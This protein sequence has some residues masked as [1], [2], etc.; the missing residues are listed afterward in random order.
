MQADFRT[1]TEKKN[2]KLLRDCLRELPG[3]CAQYFRGIEPQTTALT[4]LNYAYDLRLFFRFLTER[5]PRYAER[6]ILELTIA[7]MEKVQA[8]DLEIFME[9]ITLYEHGERELENHAP[10]K[11]RKLS[12]V[13]TMFRYLFK[14]EMISSN[15]ASLVDLPKK[16]EKPIIRLEPDEVARLLDTVETGGGLSERQRKFQ[17]Y[18][19]K[20]DV[21]LLTLFLSTGIRLSE[22][23]GID[24]GDIDFTVNGFTVTRKGG[25]RVILYFPEETAKAL[26]VYMEERSAVLP[27]PGHENALFLSLQRKRI[28]VRSVEA[29]VKRYAEV[30]APL[31]SISPHKL[32]STFGTALYR[33]TGDI[34][35]VADVLGHADV[36]TTRKHYAAMSDEKR[37]MA[38]KSIKLRED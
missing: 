36:N 7:D 20:R 13:R 2:T 4:R 29:L 21:A 35:L 22:C 31:K 12:S 17:E 28:N 5:V 30:A 1:Q 32:R 34:Y 24:I 27:C 18:T 11:E 26:R 23:V 37:R 3:F 10:G 6:N 19:K 38:A 9:Y 8:A 14:R 25:D 33:E 16:R 15:V